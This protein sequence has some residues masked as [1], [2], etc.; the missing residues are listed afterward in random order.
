M[1]I[2]DNSPS[3]VHYDFSVAAGKMST[4]DAFLKAFST[5]VVAVNS[6][7]ETFI[8]LLLASSSPC[9]LFISSGIASLGDHFNTNI[10]VNKSPPSGWP[11]P[12]TF[13]TTTYRTSKT[14]MNMM[15][16]EWCRVL[17]ED[18]VKIHIVDPGW[19]ATDLGGADKEKVKAMGAGEPIVGG[20][21]IK[22]V[23]EGE[24]DDDVGRMVSKG[25]VIP[26]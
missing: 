14:A 23:I 3:G 25:G 26:W 1:N 5:N 21:F 9:I 7:T 24:R 11:K 19:L 2:A 8:D 15:I 16:L 18:G 12:Y 20:R 6:F 13:N 17:K 4:R 10:P 22:T